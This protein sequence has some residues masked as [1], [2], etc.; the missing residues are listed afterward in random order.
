MSKLNDEIQEV[1]DNLDHLQEMLEF[2]NT[3]G[4]NEKHLKLLDNARD[5]LNRYLSVVEKFDRTGKTKN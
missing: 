1:Y 5:A 3:Y 2:D 4:K